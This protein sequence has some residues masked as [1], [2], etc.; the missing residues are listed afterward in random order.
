MAAKL[1]SDL[2]QIANFGGNQRWY[3]KVVRPVSEAELLDLLAQNANGTIK[4]LGAGHSWSGIGAGTDIAIDMTAFDSVEVFTLDGEVMVRVGA[5]C[6]LQDLLDRLHATTDRTLP[7]LGAIKKQTISGAIAT[8]THGSGRQSLSHY[9]TRVRLALF[10]PETGAPLIKEF[11][12]G[13]DLLA[14]RCGL[15]C[16]GIVISV[17]ILTVPKYLVAE[18]VRRCADIED[19]RSRFAEH[20]LTNFLWFPYRWTVMAFERRPLEARPLPPG[21]QLKS[22][23]F[24]VFS[25]IMLDILFHLLVIGFRKLGRPGVELL[26]SL[27]P[28]TVP[29]NRTRIDDSERVL[30]VHHDFFRHEEMEVF[31]AERALVE[32]CAFLRTAIEVFS[33]PDSAEREALRDQLAKL[34]IDED[35]DAIAGSY[36]HHYPLF[37]R[38]ILP[39]ATLVSMAASIEEP[40]YSISLFTYD[41]PSRR[42]PYYA[43]CSLVARV[44]V[45][46]VGAR[47]HWGKHFPLEYADI[48]PLYPRLDEFR[49]L[50]CQHDAWGVLRNG[51]TFRVLGLPPQHG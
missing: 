47:L 4:A 42:V 41:R 49:A 21:A 16:F 22:W 12:D 14:A 27:A 32:T 38:R 20:P 7:T 33:D 28:R 31:V 46:R 6:R 29:T 19:V 37:F 25:L 3:A 24:R 35:V 45:K 10:D 40:V 34:E 39:E 51:Y 9:V 8:G 44:L 48:A 18:T 17:D 43:F 15:G 36:V 30:T 13:P 1:G 23:F 5:G 11:G 50:C 26:F 2:G